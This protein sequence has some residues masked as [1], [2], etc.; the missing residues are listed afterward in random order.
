MF[1]KMER[2]AVAEGAVAAVRVVEGFD[3]VED[4]ESGDGAGGRDLSGQALSLERGDETFGHWALSQGLPVRL[5]L[6][7]TPQAAVICAKASA[8]YLHAA[9]AEPSGAR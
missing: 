7:V 3:I 9:I 1:F 2:G 6:R 8:A 5:M 4:H